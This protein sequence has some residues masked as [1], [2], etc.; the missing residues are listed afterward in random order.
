LR[1]SF[2]RAVAA[3][4]VPPATEKEQPRRRPPSS[5]VSLRAESRRARLES[6]P[7][8]VL[9]PEIGFLVGRGPPLALLRHVAGLARR[10][11]VSADAALLAEGLMAEEDFY[12]ALADHLGAPY[13]AAEVALE[14]RWPG[15]FDEDFAPMR[16]GALGPQWLAAPAGA[17]VTRLIGAARSAHGRPL[18]L[19]GARS[20]LRARRVAEA[21][22]ELAQAAAISAEIANP[23]LSTRRALTLKRALG[24]GVAALLFLACVVAPPGPLSLLAGVILGL[25][26]L[27]GVLLRLFA[28]AASFEKREPRCAIAAA[29]L[30]VYTIL[31]ALRQEQDVVPQLVAALNRLD[32]PRAKLD[33]KFI[34]EADD[35]E[36]LAALR[37]CPPFAPHEIL[38]A[39]EG[40]PRTKPRALN[41]ALPLARGSL[42]CVFDAED[43]PEP[44]QLRDAAAL[45][46]RL[47][48]SVACLQASLAIDNGRE[49]RIAQLFALDYAALFDVFNKGLAAMG[50]PLFLGGTSNHFR[51]EALRRVG[52]WDAYNVTEDAE[53]GLRLARYGYGVDTFASSTMEEAPVTPGALLRQRVRWMKGW[54][55]TALAHLRDPVRFFRDLGPRRG[56][57]AFALIVANV[58]GPLLGPL[59][60][61]R[62]LIEALCGDLLSPRTL[63]QIV[64]STLWCFLALAGAAALLAPL[65]AGM[66]RRGLTAYWRALPLLPF[67]LAMT[68]LAALIA[69]KDLLERPFFWDKTRHGLSG[70]GARAT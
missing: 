58:V 36:T 6:A 43:L 56:V 13:A 7:A 18:F 46:A 2:E 33:I 39:P 62:F 37:A 66:A 29:R 57:A 48:P 51:V 52:G 65:L 20:A 40:R 19:V 25:S 47:P 69:V 28:F 41:L 8:G 45:F 21:L 3:A 27:A 14:R 50:L 26:F 31:I 24:P 44:R 70:R 38:V 16:G 63:P 11:G 30:P 61:L 64:F 60:T 10:Q 5:P 4:G 67:W 42:L 49:S 54:L 15:A 12:R 22:P 23:Q 34:V 32:Y 68:S 59:L 35:P 53:L 17:A 1:P 55:Q 9:P